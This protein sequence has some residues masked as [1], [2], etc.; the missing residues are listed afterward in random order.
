MTYWCQYK[1]TSRIGIL[2]RKRRDTAIYTKKCL[3]RRL[4]HHTHKQM[5]KSPETVCGETA[6]GCFEGFVLLEYNAVFNIISVISRRQ[7]TY[8]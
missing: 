6:F 5:I 4:K 7:L 1:R 8:S 2:P 3:I